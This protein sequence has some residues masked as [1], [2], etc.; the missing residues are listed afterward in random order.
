MLRK[1]S[2]QSKQESCGYQRIK[3]EP[4]SSDCGVSHQRMV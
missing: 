2:L 4:K 1:T 3:F